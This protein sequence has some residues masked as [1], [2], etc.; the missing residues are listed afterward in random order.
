MLN[1]IDL[2]NESLRTFDKAILALSSGAFGLSVVFLK[3][4]AGPPPY[5]ASIYLFLG[6]G[7]FLVATIVNVMS[8]LLSCADAQRERARVDECA[9]EGK[10]YSPGKNPYRK[11]TLWAN[12]VA[13]IFFILSIIS[14]AAFAFLNVNQADHSNGKASADQT[15]F[16][17]VSSTWPER[18]PDHTSAI[19]FQAVETGCWCSNESAAGCTAHS[20]ATTEAV[21]W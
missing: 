10:L 19:D 6:W 21:G 17:T 16:A 5:I 12:S 2:G 18:S 4:I 14:L 20:E 8:Y 11:M 15:T 9:A 1:L 7:G 3:D 13:F